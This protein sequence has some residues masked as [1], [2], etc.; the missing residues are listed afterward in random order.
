LKAD[1]SS[2]LISHFF[3]CLFLIS[4]FLFLSFSLFLL[5]FLLQFLSE[6]EKL[7]DKSKTSGSVFITVK[8]CQYPPTHSHCP[9]LPASSLLSL[10][11]LDKPPVSKKKGETKKE[12]TPD[13][14]F[15][16]LVR[17]TNGKKIKFSTLV[18]LLSTNSLSL[19]PCPASSPSPPLLAYRL[20][21]TI[22]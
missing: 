8:R 10:L 9:V 18:S 12:E 6:L 16:C 19:L 5:W 1:R 3:Y 21:P 7:F 14:Q 17:A 4:L 20:T 15:P 13:E 11:S 2:F 22:C